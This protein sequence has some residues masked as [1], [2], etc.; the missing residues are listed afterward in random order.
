MPYRR[1]RRGLRK[2]LARQPRLDS[3]TPFPAK[4][5]IDT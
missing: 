1:S 5:R 4:I 2:R 3:P